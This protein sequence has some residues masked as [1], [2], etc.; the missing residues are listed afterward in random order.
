MYIYI[1][2]TR[3]SP[4]RFRNP[5][6]ESVILHSILNN[7]IPLLYFLIHLSYYNINPW[8]SAS[9]NLDDSLILVF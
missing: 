6:K 9:I 5:Q 7:S 8:A 1:D 2:Y 4:H 3:D